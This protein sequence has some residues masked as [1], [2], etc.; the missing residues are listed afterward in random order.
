MRN[1]VKLREKIKCNI[2]LSIPKM[3]CILA[4]LLSATQFHGLQTNIFVYDLLATNIHM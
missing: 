4:I 2:F 3:A 1:Q